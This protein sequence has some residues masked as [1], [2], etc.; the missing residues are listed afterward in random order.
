MEA[1]AAIARRPPLQE[2]SL[3]PVLHEHLLSGFAEA[4]QVGLPPAV[5]LLFFF[6]IMT[7]TSTE[8]THL[9][10]MKRKS[11]SYPWQSTCHVTLLKDARAFM[12]A[13]LDSLYKAKHYVILEMY[14][15]ESGQLFDQWVEAL[16]HCAKRGVAC[17]L[18]FDGYGS[19]MLAQNQRQRLQTA[20]IQLCFYN[21]LSTHN[22][23]LGLYRLLWRRLSRD[24][25]RNHRKLLIIDGHTAFTGGSGICDQF[26]DPQYGPW[27]ETMVQFS[28]PVIEDWLSIFMQAWPKPLPIP[29]LP[30]S[31]TG[32]MQCRLS[33]SSHQRN[34]D[35]K[36][37]ML[38]LCGDAQQRIW[39]STAYFVPSWKLRRRLVAAARR[40]VDVRLLLPGSHTDH[41]WVR[42]AGRRFYTHLLHHGVKIYEYQPRFLHAKV[43]LCDH[44]ASIGSCNFDRWGMRWNLDANLEIK[45]TKFISELIRLFEQ[46]FAES[47]TLNYHHWSQRS[48]RLRMLERFWGKIDLLLAQISNWLKR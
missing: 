25:Y 8:S 10:Y 41:P 19:L 3:K 13:M 27:R 26:V 21:P 37:S 12:P 30:P 14:L 45:D 24:L 18:L 43:L 4:L 28:G 47:Q 39:L 34:N 48:W 5:T 46:D 22:P 40:G 11:L 7:T 35:L 31:A 44:T 42:H 9:F 33:H 20:N 1:S 6:V 29:K 2:A 17:Y 36:R 38:T 15:V 23:F 32:Q 16:C